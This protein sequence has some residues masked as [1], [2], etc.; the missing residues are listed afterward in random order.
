MKTAHLIKRYRATQTKYRSESIAP[1]QN[2][3]TDET[4]LTP[5]E[6]AEYL[7]VSYKR[8]LNMS[9]NGQIPYYKRGASNLYL[10]SELKL[11]LEKSR[12]GPKL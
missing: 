8:L 7:R 4:W 11:M 3:S 12:R 2:V 9:S 10:K 1:L 6:A 5:A